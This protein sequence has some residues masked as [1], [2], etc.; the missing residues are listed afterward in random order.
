MGFETNRKTH[1]KFGNISEEVCIG[2]KTFR[3]DS[4]GEKRLAEYLELLKIGGYIKDW[5]REQTTFR[6][7]DGDPFWKVDFDVLNNDG[8]FCYYEFKGPVQQG[9]ITKLQ[10]LFECRPEV[11]I[12][13]VFENK[14]SAAKFARRKVSRRC[15]G[16]WI[17]STSGKGLTEFDGKTPR[18]R[19]KS[20]RGL[21]R[22]REKGKS[23][24]YRT[25]IPET[26]LR[27]ARRLKRDNRF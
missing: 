11:Q 21:R 26:I 4:Q 10:L 13:F 2:G 18:K 16:I 8:S 17:Q 5:A 15:K 6:T 7:S 23:D 20:L 19:A 24:P 25:D 22:T 27:K 3:V 1:R 12:H 14:T 9:D